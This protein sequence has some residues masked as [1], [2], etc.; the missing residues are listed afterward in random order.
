MIYCLVER[1]ADEVVRG[2]RFDLNNDKFH[3]LLVNGFAAL[4]TMI[5]PHTEPF[6]SDER[7]L[8]TI[9]RILEDRQ[10]VLI[11]VHGS[12]MVFA[13]I[14]T[15]SVGVFVARYFKKTWVN[16]KICGNQAWFFWHFL[17]MIF[18]FILTISSV[19]IIFVEMGEWRTTV[20]AISG[21]IVTAFVV[22]QPI[23]AVFRPKPTSRNRPIFN[24]L[25]FSFGNVTHILALITIFLAVPLVNARLPD[26]TIYVLIAFVVFYLLMHVL[27]TVT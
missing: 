27:M 14:G 24:F 11:M 13:W 10:R 17:C 23:G 3:L 26:W 25:H 16:Q 1:N 6:S 22:L 15:A 12:L 8:L 19:I 20:H 7:V 4:P 18:T 9:P 2:R 5:G 21:I